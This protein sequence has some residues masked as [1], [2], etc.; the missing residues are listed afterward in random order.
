[1]AKRIGRSASTERVNNGS[2]KY[3]SAK[4]GRFVV[5]K[6]EARAAARTKVTVDQKLG[7]DT[8]G[9]VQDLAKS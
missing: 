3:R 4:S 6:S 9:W 5:T 7:K 8:P 2:S 1:M